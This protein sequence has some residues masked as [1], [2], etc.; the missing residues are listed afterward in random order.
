MCIAVNVL[1]GAVFT[2]HFLCTPAI[3]PDIVAAPSKH[4]EITEDQS[5]SKL[6]R[7]LWSCSKIDW[8]STPSSL[9]R[10]IGLF[11]FHQNSAGQRPFAHG[12]H[13][14]WSHLQSLK[15]IYLSVKI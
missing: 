9:L 3:D 11:S 7:T 12:V 14:H 2:L 8:A 13:N 5:T 6:W 10:Q 1:Y 15:L 4:R